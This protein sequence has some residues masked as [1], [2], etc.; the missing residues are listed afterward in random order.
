MTNFCRNTNE[1]MWQVRRNFIAIGTKS[2]AKPI[3]CDAA[4]ECATKSRRNLRQNYVVISTSV[5]SQNHIYDGLVV[6]VTKLRGKVRRSFVAIATVMVKSK[7]KSDEIPS[8]L[9]R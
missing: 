3:T 7:K 2:Y 4:A 5:I 8:I 9:R 6:Y 1:E